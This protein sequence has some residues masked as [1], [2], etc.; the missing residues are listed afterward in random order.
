MLRCSA[1]T[2]LAGLALVGLIGLSAAF[3]FHPVPHE[4]HDFLIFSLGALAGAITVGG[5]RAA[6][7]ALTPPKLPGPPA[8]PGA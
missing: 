8:E 5:S 2:V 3:V 6:G 4:N 7:A 1:E